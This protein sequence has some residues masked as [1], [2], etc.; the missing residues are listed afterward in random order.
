V[1]RLF[2]VVLVCFHYGV[3]AY[4]DGLSVSV[5]D[6]GAF[7][8]G[9]TGHTYPAPCNNPPAPDDTCAINQALDAVGQTPG[10][11]EVIIPPGTCII[12]PKPDSQQPGPN[13]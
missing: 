1:K 2:I 7:C 13:Q 4:G 6:Y 10:G 9:Q 11:G 8:D 12:S 3:R 5:R